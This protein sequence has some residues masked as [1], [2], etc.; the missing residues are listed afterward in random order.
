MNKLLTYLKGVDESLKRQTTTVKVLFGLGIFTLVAIINN[1]VKAPEA[2]SPTSLTT[3]S[4]TTPPPSKAQLA[5]ELAGHERDAREAERGALVAEIE[6]R[7]HQTSNPEGLVQAFERNE[8]RVTQDFEDKSLTVAGAVEKVGLDILNNAYVIA[9]PVSGF[10]RVQCTFARPQDVSLIH[11]GQSVIIEGLCRGLMGNVLLDE[12][13]LSPNLAGEA[14]EVAQR[15][16]L[17]APSHIPPRRTHRPRQQ[18]PA[19]TTGTAANP[20]G[21]A[22]VA[23]RTQPHHNHLPQPERV[24]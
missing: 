23:G 22:A 14:K 11:K 17:A 19:R 1:V 21:Q 3:S 10:R 8:V 7:K 24:S 4:P 16:A 2:P 12:F 18:R 15:V 20:A 9:G 6:G 5:R 13:E